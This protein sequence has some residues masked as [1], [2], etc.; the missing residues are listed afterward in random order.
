MFVYLHRTQGGWFDVVG[1]EFP[2]M[3]SVEEIET[4]VNLCRLHIQLA[5]RW[6]VHGSVY[7]TRQSASIPVY[8]VESIEKVLEN[9]DMKTVSSLEQI[10]TRLGAIQTFFPTDDCFVEYHDRL[11]VEDLMEIED[12]MADPM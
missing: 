6:F 8:S 10:F 3:V 4:W 7:S 9:I 2:S 11:A 5:C 1:L 12:F